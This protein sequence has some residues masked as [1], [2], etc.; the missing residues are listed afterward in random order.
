MMFYGK[1]LLY[2]C[3]LIIV[4]YNALTLNVCENEHFQVQF[5]IFTHLY[6]QLVNIFYL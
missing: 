2:Y 4:G 5:N 6:N 1:Q 3:N